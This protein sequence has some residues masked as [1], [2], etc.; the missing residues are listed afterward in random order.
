M[1]FIS[2]IFFF[3]I[4]CEF[5]NSRVSVHVFSK[6]YSDSLLARTMTLRGNNSRILAKI[7]FLRI[8]PD[9]QYV[10]EYLCY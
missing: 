5:L 3:R 8:F 2:R 10:I 9:L 6:V 7:K 4:I 1:T